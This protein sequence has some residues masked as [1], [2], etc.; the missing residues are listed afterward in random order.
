MTVTPTSCGDEYSDLRE[1]S[2]R[3]IESQIRADYSNIFIRKIRFAD[4][5]KSYPCDNFI[6]RHQGWRWRII[7]RCKRL[8]G[9]IARYCFVFAFRIAIFSGKKNRSIVSEFCKI[10]F[11]VYAPPFNIKIFFRIMHFLTF[12]VITMRRLYQDNLSHNE[13]KIANRSNHMY[14][15]CKVQF[16][17]AESLNYSHIDGSNASIYSCFIRSSFILRFAS[18][19]YF[20]FFFATAK[21]LERRGRIKKIILRGLYITSW[22]ACERRE[23]LLNF[24]A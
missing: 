12:F 5:P 2:F 14:S 10:F 19:T 15:I 24:M 7:K 3:K 13:K 16:Y 6:F 23:V 21:G 22:R 20:V 8:F 9:F 1:L 18:R 11:S 17:V 4:F